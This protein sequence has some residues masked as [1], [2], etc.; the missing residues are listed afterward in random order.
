MQFL[1]CIKKSTT[2]KS[3]ITNIFQIWRPFYLSYTCVTKSPFSYSHKR[4]W[5][6]Y[7]FSIMHCSIQIKSIIANSYS[8]ISY[9]IFF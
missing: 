3:T 4:I 9:F 5:T 2:T 1:F 7:L 8:T 6:K